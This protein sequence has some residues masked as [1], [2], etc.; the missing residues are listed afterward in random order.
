MA[1]TETG[2]GEENGGVADEITV[3]RRITNAIAALDGDPAAQE[4]VINY[5]N[6][7]YYPKLKLVLPAERAAGPS[8]A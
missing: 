2:K 6:A 4:R 8:E 7:K 1:K 5:L 3:M